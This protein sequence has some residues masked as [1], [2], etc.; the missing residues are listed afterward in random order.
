MPPSITVV[1]L[2]RGPEHHASLSGMPPV[3][4]YFTRP[5]V[6][7]WVYFTRNLSLAELLVTCFRGI[8][9]P[10]VYSNVMEVKVSWT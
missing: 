8:V 3:D 6:G 9:L 4:R 5:G 2:S 10:P 7:G 1:L